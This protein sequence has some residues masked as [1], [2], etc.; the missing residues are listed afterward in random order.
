MIFNTADIGHE[1]LIGMHNLMSTRIK[2]STKPPK[3]VCLIEI[4]C[5]YRAILTRN[6]NLNLLPTLISKDT[7]MNID[8]VRNIDK[9]LDTV[10]DVVVEVVD[11]S[12]R[13]PARLTIMTH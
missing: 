5:L 4:R 1:E 2:K 9:V 8:C 13:M 3:I 11:E 12:N 10:G 6:I 7:G